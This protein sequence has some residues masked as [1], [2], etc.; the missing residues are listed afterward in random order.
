L[1]VTSQEE[2]RE[3]LLKKLDYR[4]SQMEIT[5]LGTLVKNISLS[6]S[7]RSGDKSK[8]DKDILYYEVGLRDIDEHNVITI[9]RCKDKKLGGASKYLIDKYSLKKNDLLISY[10]ASHNMKVARVGSDY[11]H[12]LVTNASVIR[13]QMHEGTPKELAL[14]IQAYLSIDYIQHYIL[15]RDVKSPERRFSR[16]LVSTKLLTELP[17]PYFTK[18]MVAEGNFSNIYLKHLEI[19]NKLSTL[20]KESR[21]LINCLSKDEDETI[22]LFLHHKKELPKVL[23]KDMFVLGKVDQ[24]LQRGV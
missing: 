8:F 7:V 11:L 1:E 17:I 20:F 19:E 21:N 2:R 10:R 6:P 12:P 14:L 3:D 22:N 24:L 5:T 4:F 13:I 9:E 15:P 23:E 18:E 16:P